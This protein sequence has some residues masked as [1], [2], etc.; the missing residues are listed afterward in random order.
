MQKDWEILLHVASISYLTV[1]HGIIRLQRKPKL[2]NP[3]HINTAN[4]RIITTGNT[5]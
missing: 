3:T 2:Y 5:L 1:Y 4:N